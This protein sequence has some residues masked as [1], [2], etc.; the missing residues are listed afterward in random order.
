M[1]KFV[2]FEF[3]IYARRDDHDGR[4]LFGSRYDGRHDGSCD[5]GAV[6]S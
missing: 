1:K 3:S 4:W 5:R 2:K 6:S